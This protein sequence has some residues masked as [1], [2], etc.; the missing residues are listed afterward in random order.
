MLRLFSDKTLRNE[1][2]NIDFGETEEETSKEL[3]IY[4]YNDSKNAYVKDIEYPIIPNVYIEGFKTMKP[5]EVKPLILVWT[6]K[7]KK[8]LN[9]EL[10]IT[11]TEVYYPY[12]SPQPTHTKSMKEKLSKSE[13]YCDICSV[14]YHNLKDYEDHLFFHDKEE[15][16]KERDRLHKEIEGNEH[17]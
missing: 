7:E 14:M 9:F 15:M 17:D 10:N 1:I 8:P 4:V 11:A 2:R 3:T 16:M 5:L 6:V 12:G 13:V